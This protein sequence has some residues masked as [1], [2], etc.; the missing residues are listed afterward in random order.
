MEPTGKNEKRRFMQFMFKPT[1]ACNLACR[2]CHIHRDRDREHS[3]ID[4]DQAKKVFHWILDYCLSVGVNRTDIL[5]HGG[6]PLLVK[7]PLM[8]E[9]IEYYTELFSRHDIAVT[10]TIQTNLLLFDDAYFPIIEKYFDNTIGFS[11]DFNATDRCYANGR[12]A[13]ADIWKK[14][15]Q[16]KARG[17]NLGAITQITKDNHQRIGELYQMFK[18]MGVN[19]KFSRIRETDIFHESLSDDDYV[20]AVTKL[21]IEWVED[22]AQTIVI[23]NFVE[24]IGMLLAGRYSSCC[25]QKDCNILSFTNDGSIFFCDRSFQG[26]AVG[27]IHRDTPAQVKANVL[28]SIK[29]EAARSDECET[30][31]YRQICNSGC[32]YNRISGWHKHECVSFYGILNFIS[33][34]LVKQGYNVIL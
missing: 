16:L 10:N 22:S 2:Y 17:I 24:F 18:Q 34:Y 30:C 28:A 19:F 31:K 29:K 27:S 23:S 11:F 9:I 12:N 6:E 25:Y 13:S 8:T 4:L 1:L 20:E 21:F 33:D 32:L 15:S 14:A 7:A 5:W 3:I 26:G